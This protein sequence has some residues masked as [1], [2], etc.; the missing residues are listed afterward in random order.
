MNELLAIILFVAYAEQFGENFEISTTAASALS[1]LNSPKGIEAD[2]YWLF[3]RV[4]ELGM[5]ELFNPVVNDRRPTK[6]DDLFSWN[7]ERNKNDLVGKDKSYEDDASSVLRRSHRIHHRFLQ[8]VDKQ[9]Y[10]HLEAQKIEPNIYLQRYLRCMLTREFTVPAT[11]II[12]DALFASSNFPNQNNREIL[13][14]DYMCVAMIVF[15][16]AHCDFYLV[17]ECD[18]SGILRRLLRFPPVEDVHAIIDSAINFMEKVKLSATNA[19]SRLSTNLV[20]KPPT[21]KKLAVSTKDSINSTNSQELP[22][23]NI[24][25]YLNNFPVLEKS[26]SNKTDD[27]LSSQPVSPVKRQVKVSSQIL[28][29]KLDTAIGLLEIQ[30][31]E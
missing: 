11:L 31:N 26:K 14:L 12:W 9:L 10:D 19:I 25:K 15:V 28:I 8:T 18:N 2:T 4:M 17:L 1:I 13:L 27:N 6:N 29:D 22:H 3:S 24:E 21:A 23:L 30:M 16:R 7:Y 20:Q 5:M